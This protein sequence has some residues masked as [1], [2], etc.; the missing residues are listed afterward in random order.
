[1]FIEDTE[2]PSQRNEKK[3]TPITIYAL[4]RE[5]KVATTCNTSSYGGSDGSCEVT[6]C[7]QQRREPAAA[8]KGHDGSTNQDEGSTTEDEDR[9]LRRT[10][11]DKTCENNVEE[12]N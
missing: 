2:R 6:T 11:E 8:T 9:R 7:M 4:P 1:M 12:T 5:P 10:Y 3:K